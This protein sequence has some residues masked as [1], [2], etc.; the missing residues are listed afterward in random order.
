M[1][2]GVVVCLF[3]C[4]FVVVF[5]VVCGCMWLYGVA[6]LFVCLFCCCILLYV[7]VCCWLFV[8]FVVVVI[9]V[10]CLFLCLLLFDSM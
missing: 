8:C 4:W 6:C 3:D 2:V 10:V 9:V 7:V 1:F 5:V